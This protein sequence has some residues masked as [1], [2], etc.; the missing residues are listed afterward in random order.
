M[1]ANGKMRLSSVLKHQEQ[2]GEIHLSEDFGY[3]YNTI[4]KN[5]VV[6]VLINTSVKI[7]RMPRMA[8]NISMKT[9]NK[10]LKGLKFF[11]GYNWYSKD[12]ELLIESISAF[13]LVSANEHKIVKPVA[14]GFE[15]P[16]ETDRETSLQNPSKTHIPQEMDLIGEK[17]VS[18]SMLDI[19]NHLNN[20]LYADL[21]VDFITMEQALN[22][23]QITLDYVKEAVFEDTIKI[24]S[25]TIDNVIYL[26][27]EVNGE[28]CFR[29]S[30]TI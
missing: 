11:R 14:L 9:W 20:A 29:A 26:K 10:E 13:V 1:G 30:I 22:L 15:L 6:F 28:I 18:F 27:G 24:Y 23:K 2:A 5:G 16:E 4:R 12:G 8:E 19:N 21:L 17:R 7:H 25:K 3:D